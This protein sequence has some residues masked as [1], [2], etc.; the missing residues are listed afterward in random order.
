[1]SKGITGFSKVMANL[2]AEIAAME[3]ASMKGLI[4]GTIIVQRSMETTPP[5]IP[6]DLGNLRSSW[7]NYGFR[8]GLGPTRVIGFSANYAVFIHEDMKPK[9]FKRPGSGPKFLEYAIKRNQ[10]EILAAIAGNIKSTL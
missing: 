3:A 1:M 4:R 10:P 9:N 7:F 2:N 8:T 5:L 6:L